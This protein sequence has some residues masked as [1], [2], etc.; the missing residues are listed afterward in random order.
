MDDQI[1]LVPGEPYEPDGPAE[2]PVRSARRRALG[3]TALL[4]TAAVAVG[5]QHVRTSHLPVAVVAAPRIS[6]LSTPQYQPWPQGTGVCGSSLELPQISSDVLTESTRTT[7]PV[8]G[9]LPAVVNVDTGQRS[10]IPGLRLRPDQYASAI[11]RSG[12]ADYVLVRSCQR[13]WMATVVRTQAGQPQ[14]VVSGDRAVFG[15]IGDDAGAVWAEAYPN[16]TKVTPAEAVGTVL[17]RLD[18]PAPAVRLP[19][20]LNV[21]GI[22]GNQVAATAAGPPQA[23]TLSRLY[24]FDLTT[25]RASLLGMAYSATESRGVLL[26]TS[27]PCSAIGACALRSYDLRTGSAGLQDFHLPLGSGVTGGVLSPDGR[28]LAFALQREIPD[29]Y[30]RSSSSQNNP[31]DLVVLDLTTGVVDPVPNLELPPDDDPAITFSADSNW[32]I[33]ALPADG[34]IDVYSWRSG[35]TMPQLTPRPESWAWPGLTEKQVSPQ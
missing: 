16:A 26:W 10:D 15:L 1:Y 7:V 23:V 25:R 31:A 6:V 4:V 35:M 33:V 19:A 27:T 29:A 17:V 11:V 3:L 9:A 13:R 24:R 14:Q 22:A 34:G 8:A 28:R 18:R 21:V 20:A 2:P 5:V 32:L 12:S 30:Y